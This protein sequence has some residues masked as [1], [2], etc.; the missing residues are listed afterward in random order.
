MRGPRGCT[1]AL[2]KTKIS[3]PSRQK[4]H[5]FSYTQ[6]EIRNFV[7]IFSPSLTEMIDTLRVTYLG[8]TPRGKE[9]KV[10]AAMM[11]YVAAV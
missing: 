1:Y 3:F 6:H 2:D 11:Q 5:D 4:K 9:S 10:N 8:F 7:E